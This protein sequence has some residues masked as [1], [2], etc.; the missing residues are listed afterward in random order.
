MW[1]FVQLYASLLLPIPCIPL[2]LHSGR[3]THCVQNTGLDNVKNSNNFLNILPR[4][5][6]SSLC[7]GNT[8]VLRRKKTGGPCCFRKAKRQRTQSP[9]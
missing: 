7:T 2:N 4:S 1:K 5:L 3:E 8:A 6:Q 9:V